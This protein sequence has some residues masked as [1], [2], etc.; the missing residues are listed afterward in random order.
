MLIE[1]GKKIVSNQR[2][3]YEVLI[4]ISKSVPKGVVLTEL[5][6]KNQDEFTLSGESKKDS[7]I[8]KLIDNL[9][10]SES[11]LKATL[12]TMGVREAGEVSKKVK[13][14]NISLKIKLETTKETETV[15]G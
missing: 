4:E 6:F 5:I 3:S 2:Q 8:I 9:N 1:K 11:I 14:F 7:G 15:E 10:N 12:N 13:I